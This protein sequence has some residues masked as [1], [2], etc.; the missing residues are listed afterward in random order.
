MVI[1][2]DSSSRLFMQIESMFLEESL[3]QLTSLE[4]INS[5]LADVPP[6]ICRLQLLRRL[7]LDRN[8]LT[9]LP[10][11]CFVHLS[12]LM[13]LTAVNNAI[14]ELQDGIFDG[15]T[16]LELIDLSFN[17]IKS[18]GQR[19]FINASDLTSLHTIHLN[20]N[21][22]T[23][24]DAWPIVRGRVAG[25]SKRQVFV[26][27]WHNSIAAFTNSAGVPVGCG[28]SAPFLILD[29]TFNDVTR[30]TDLLRG[31][32]ITSFTE[33]LC[34]IGKWPDGN[35]SRLQLNIAGTRQMICDCVD[36]VYYSTAVIFRKSLIFS[37]TFCSKP[38][39]FE[40]Y[41]SFTHYA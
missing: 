31:L 34:L 32:G 15:M 2:N 24:L 9:R 18:I 39:D 27:L 33:A 1:V 30:M 35:K 36:F 20:H 16:K 37:E 10:G 19:V 40:R 7:C 28:H 25:T 26:G 17:Y 12:Q 23:V 4:I 38:D 3:S 22:L 41:G 21:Q 29:L 11:D 6:S 8:G 13:N 5:P 14:T